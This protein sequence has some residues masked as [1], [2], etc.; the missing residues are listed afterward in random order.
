MDGQSA[1]HFL[2]EWGRIA[3]GESLEIVPFLDRR[4]LWAGEQLPPFASSP[5]YEGEEFEEPPLLIGETD[6]V[7][8]RKKETVVAM[9]K[10]SKSQLQKLRSKVNTSEYADPARGFTRYETVTGHVWRC[11]CK[12][13]GHS[14]EQPTGLVISVDARSRVQP[15]LPRGYFG[16]A[17]H[18]VVAASISGTFLSIFF[19]FLSKIKIYF[20]L[21]YSWLYLR[22][23]Y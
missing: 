20:V 7:E 22:F 17:T 19:F 18:D 5:Q 14:P 10:L 21:F 9:L 12:A 8:E 4:V 13:R 6:C 3:R 1:L 16:N 23:I 2:S 15:P 11:A